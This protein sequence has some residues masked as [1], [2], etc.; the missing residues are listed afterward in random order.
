[1]EKKCSRSR[2]GKKRFSKRST[3]D[4]SVVAPTSLQHV[5]H[6]LLYPETVEDREYQRAISQA[7]KDRN[8]LVVLPTALGKT[9]ISAL[10]AV[11]VLYNHRGKRVLV[12][13]PT[14]PLC[15]QHMETFRR[16]MRLPGDA[17]VHLTGKTQAE[18]READWNGRSRMVFA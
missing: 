5:S 7:A 17:F 4:R 3:C 9:I 15:M 10:V 8:S 6:P 18:F 14:R 16:V 11:D 1:M 13:A 2:K 12:M